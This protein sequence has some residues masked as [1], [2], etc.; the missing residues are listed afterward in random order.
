MFWKSTT[1]SAAEPPRSNTHFHRLTPALSTL[2]TP[3]HTTVPNTL[4]PGFIS[5]G[6]EGLAGSAGL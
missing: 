4:S 6:M 3:A 5:A 1:V 2:F